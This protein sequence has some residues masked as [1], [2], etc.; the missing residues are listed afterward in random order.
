ML[1]STIHADFIDNPP[2][3]TDRPGLTTRFLKR[4][5]RFL[6]VTVFVAEC[7]PVHPAQRFH[8]VSEMLIEP[9]IGIALA[10]HN[11]LAVCLLAAPIGAGV[12]YDE[13]VGRTAEPPEPFE[14][15]APA[16]ARL[17]LGREECRAPKACL[18]QIHE[19]SCAQDVVELPAIIAIVN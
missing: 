13:M 3:T 19:H 9:R 11:L 15:E 4:F 8:P 6:D 12:D 10:Q 2:Q 1:A 17:L 5:V 18:E 14:Q 16:P 7:N